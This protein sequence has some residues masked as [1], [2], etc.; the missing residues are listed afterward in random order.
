MHLFLLG[1]EGTAEGTAEGSREPELLPTGFLL[2]L[3]PFQG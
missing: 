2:L 1:A 3:P